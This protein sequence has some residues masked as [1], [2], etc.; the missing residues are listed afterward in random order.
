MNNIKLTIAECIDES[1]YEDAIPLLLS[2]ESSEIE[3]WALY[4]ALGQCYRL[5]GRIP[6]ACR[7]L[8]VAREMNC[9][10]V[11]LAYAL[12]DAYH[13]SIRYEEAIHSF[14]DVISLYPNRIAAYN[15]IGF[16]YTQTGK[17]GKAEEWYQKGL[18]QISALQQAGVVM[19]Q[20]SYDAYI[21]SIDMDLG[22]VFPLRRREDTVELDLLEA[23]ITNNMGVCYLQQ[24]KYDKARVCFRKSMG[25]IP[26]ES[27]YDDPKRYLLELEGMSRYGEDAYRNA[28]EAYG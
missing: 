16:I 23:V 7:F 11:E 13:L 9:M 15:K 4:Y 22:V 28:G 6:L 2:L 21:N 10:H 19:R 18:S 17:L 8:E 20:K 27:A 12:G 26:E 24:K 25:M 14:E 5:A 3:A 1:R